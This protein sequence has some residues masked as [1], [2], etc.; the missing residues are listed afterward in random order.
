M[1]IS[2]QACTFHCPALACA[3]SWF[4]KDLSLELLSTM[5]VRHN[6]FPRAVEFHGHVPI[7]CWTQ[8]YIKP[9]VRKSTIFSTRGKKFMSHCHFGLEQISVWKF[10]ADTA[11][12]WQS[13][14]EIHGFSPPPLRPDP[15]GGEKFRVLRCPRYEFQC[16]LP[17]SGPR[18][19]T[20]LS[21]LP[22]DKGEEL[23][24]GGGNLRKVALNSVPRATQ[25]AK[26]I[27]RAMFC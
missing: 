13:A 12:E 16:N 24:A 27:S 15:P 22:E 10:S 23:C 18:L 11:S 14:L 2:C 20:A 9:D 17:E 6:F 3:K 25:D 4:G 26:A 7:H 19:H 5:N 21:P 1:G 8:V